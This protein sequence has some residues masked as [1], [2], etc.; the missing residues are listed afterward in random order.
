L[1][2]RDPSRVGGATITTAARATI[3]RSNA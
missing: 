3:R 1:A 2:E